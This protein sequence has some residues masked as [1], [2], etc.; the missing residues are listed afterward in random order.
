MHKKQ[1]FYQVYLPIILSVILIYIFA[2][3]LVGGAYSGRFILAAV[4]D[5]SAIYI[6]FLILFP[7]LL[8]F[9]LLTA[10]I[11]L[12]TRAPGTIRYVFKKISSFHEGVSERLRKSANMMI[13]P[14]TKMG[15][16][17]AL[18]KIQDIFQGLKDDREK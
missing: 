2:Y 14:M 9:L 8:I 5:I 7:G 15:A 6:I 16:L 4:G 17:G 12:L 10:L 18:F 13:K 11:A 1:S 3:F